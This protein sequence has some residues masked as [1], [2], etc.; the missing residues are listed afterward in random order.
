MRRALLLVISLA[1]S[2]FVVELGLRATELVYYRPIP[3]PLEDESW[4]RLSVRRSEVPGLA[5]ELVPDSSLPWRRW[6]TETNSYGMRDREPLP[7]ADGLVRIAAVGDSFT[8]GW[9]VR[10]DQGYPDVLEQRLNDGAEPGV[11]FDV[12]NFG[13]SGYSSRDEALVIEHKVVPWNP[14]VIVIGYV[15]NDPEITAL[16]PLQA[17]FVPTEW[18][19]HSYL[20]RLLAQVRWEAKVRRLGDGDYYRY[21]Y[22]DTERWNS[23]VE[24]FADIGRTADRTGAR[25]LLVVFP[26]I[27]PPDG[28][29]DD[30]NYADLHVQIGE[31]GR[32][33]GF[34]VLDL[35]SRFSKYKPRQF[36]VTEADRHPNWRGHNLAARAIEHRLTHD[37]ADAIAVTPAP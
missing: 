29:W 27:P 15:L 19:R 14:R 36:G 4:G 23:V 16:Q 22:A 13:V 1:V 17:A 30:Y 25:V 31:L 24:A 18:W 6:M 8:F 9:K 10:P 33:N 35:Y 12:L 21:L 3:P 26:R 20:L 11:E 5:Y 7:D 28:S 2:L 37:L 32:S 34:T